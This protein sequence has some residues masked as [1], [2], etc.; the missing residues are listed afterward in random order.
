MWARK[1]GRYLF[2]KFDLRLSSLYVQWFLLRRWTKRQ[3]RGR[4]LPQSRLT[5]DCCE[6][7]QVWQVN[8][9]G[10]LAWNVGMNNYACCVIYTCC[11]IFWVF[12]LVES[13][14]MKWVF[15]LTNYLSQCC[16]LWY[17]S[18]VFYPNFHVT[19]QCCFFVADVRFGFGMFSVWD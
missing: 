17:P 2:Q 6:T 14:P 7:W 4:H 16:F 11:V 19:S 10:C 8:P 9:Y 15:L 13:P 18:V 5:K 3:P 1:I 12:E